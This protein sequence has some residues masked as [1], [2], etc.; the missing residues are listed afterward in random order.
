MIN[1]LSVSH[2]D[3]E[4]QNVEAKGALLS[5]SRE[6]IGYTEPASTAPASVEFDINGSIQEVQMQS[7]TEH[8]EFEYARTDLP[9]S[10]P[11]RAKID[12]TVW[13]VYRAYVLP[14]GVD[15]SHE[16]A[17]GYDVILTREAQTQVRSFAFQ[18]ANALNNGSAWPNIKA[19]RP[20][21]APVGLV[22]QDLVGFT[23]MKWAE[24]D[25]VEAGDVVSHDNG[26]TRGLWRADTA[27]TAE[28]AQ[29]HSDWTLVFEVTV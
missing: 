6:E 7:Y 10:R 18:A 21:K 5:L 11:L 1:G 13:V 15:H 22:R 24:A 29:G 26:T 19:P 2:K 27:T 25:T 28:P 12:G 14:G 23:K 9:T 4:V 16:V 8:P 20:P 17:E 3:G